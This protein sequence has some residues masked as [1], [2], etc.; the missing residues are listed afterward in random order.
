MAVRSFALSLCLLGLIHAAPKDAAAQPVDQQARYAVMGR[1]LDQ[2]R[3]PIAGAAVIAVGSGGA[4]SLRTPVTTETTDGL[5]AFS[6]ML[7]AGRFELVV[8]ADGFRD[9]VQVVTVPGG[10]RMDIVLAVKGLEES[11]TVSA[12]S[13]AAQ[14]IASATRTLTALRD[15][16]QSVSVVTQT[17]LQDRLAAGIGDAL[18]Y[19]PGISMHQGENNRDQVIIRGNSSS[20]D[21]F[22]NSVR[23]DV[24]YFRDVYSLE[25]IEAL[26]GPNAL[27]F[28]RGG[29]GGVINRVP[30]EAGSRA[31]HE[32]TLLGGMFGQSRVTVDVN[33]PLGRRAALRVNGMAERGDSF[34]DG[35]SLERYGLTP[36]V[37]LTP[38]QATRVVVSYEHLRD[39]RTADRGIT[40]VAGRPAAVDPGLYYGN[41]DDSRVRARVHL[42]TAA[43][44]QRIGRVTLRQHTIV[45]RYD[46][47]YQNYVPGAASADR[48][49]VSLSAYNNATARANVFSQTDVFVPVATGLVTHA[50][51]G[52]VEVGRQLT[53]NFRRTGYFGGTSTTVS[54]PFFSPTIAARA[55]FRQSATD[56]DNHLRTSVA[57]AFVQDQVT[58]SR[59]L[60]VL[61]GA[62]V[63][64]F[65][66]DY[67][68]N[69]TGDRLTRP[70]TLLSPRA[71]MVVKP[72]R[73]VSLYGSYSVSHLPSSGDQFSSLTAIT[74]QVKPER[75]TNLETGLKWDLADALALTAAGYRL[76]RTNTRATDPN[77]PSKIV[78][79]GS[80]RTD[81][82]EVGANGR[83]AAWL[84]VEGGYALQRARVTAATVSAAAGATVPQ[85]PR[86]ML[87]L[88]QR[89]RLHPRVEVGFGVTHRTDVFAAIDNTVVLPGYTRADAAAYWSLG[90]H[91]RLQVNVDNVFGV[92]YFG[93]ADNNT[94]ISPGIPRTARAAVM[95]R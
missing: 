71:G 26:K 70:D 76:D 90:R 32:A 93:N 16:P 8:V 43:A 58:I 39:D 50:I 41:P 23:D 17:A 19:V 13:G 5:G 78:Q 91:A 59:Y 29:G 40:S 67:T 74:Q 31:T 45:A 95:I 51:V 22:V 54:V 44:E 37:T 49:V 62:R 1:V 2:T 86:H 52:G 80:Q 87:S 69:R 11:V 21:F 12:A 46:R 55:T 4:A 81:G 72:A 30:K 89:F 28:G 60:Q 73:L 83:V 68:N 27:A 64:R 33:Q 65:A 7:P 24:Q 92:H 48:S 88:W 63:D 84:H 3:A 10:D 82:V 75:F 79:T 36:T 20:A 9:A 25:R 77:D 18:R 38:W 35:V 61:G 6:L 57:A 56:A 94:N 42:W 14:A 85:V 66:L 53:D 34:R 15:V 47:G